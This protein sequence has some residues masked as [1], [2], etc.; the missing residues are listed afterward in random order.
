MEEI[1]VTNQV[2]DN[3]NLELSNSEETTQTSKILN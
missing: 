1:D 2:T 3:E